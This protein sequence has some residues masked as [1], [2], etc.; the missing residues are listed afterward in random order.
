MNG[1]YSRRATLRRWLIDPLRPLP[2]SAVG[3]ARFSAGLWLALAILGGFFIFFPLATSSET[4]SEAGANYTGLVAVLTAYLLSRYGQHQLAAFTIMMMMCL[5]IAI[6]AAPNGELLYPTFLFYLVIP[7][8]ISSIFLPLI[9]TIITGAGMLI[10]AGAIY[11]LTGATLPDFYDNAPLAFI[12][13]VSLLL[14]ANSYHRRQLER[15]RQAAIAWREAQLRKVIDK[16]PVLV[17]AIDEDGIIRYWNA[18]CER[19]TGYQASEIV[20][21]ANGVN[22]IYPDTSYLQ[23]MLEAVPPYT[24]YRN[25]ITRLTCKDGTTRMVAWSNIAEEIGLE[26]YAEWGVG[27]D[28]T[29]QL[30]RER[31][32]AA[33]AGMSMA[34]RAVNTRAGV[35]RETLDQISTLLGGLGASFALQHYESGQPFLVIE[36]AKNQWKEHTGL[37]IPSTD[38]GYQTVVEQKQ[39]LI[40]NTPAELNQLFRADLMGKVGAFAAVPL[41]V[42]ETVIGALGVGREAHFAAEDIRILTA[43]ADIAANAIRRVEG[44]E[45]LEQ[46]VAERT[47]ALEK[48]YTQLK[49]LDHLKG[50]LLSDIS[51]ELRTPASNLAVYLYLLESDSGSQLSAKRLQTLKDQVMRLNK[52]I[53]GVL[54]ILRLELN[55]AEVELGAV[56]LGPLV[57]L[58]ASPIYARATAKGLSLTVDIP[59][60]LPPVLAHSGYLSQLITH[61]LDNAVAYTL[62]GGIT[63]TAENIPEKRQICL[64]VAD[65][66]IGIPAEDMP[67]LYERFYRGKLA[68]QSNIPG[69]GLGLSLVKGILDVVGGEISISS[70]P[71]IGT[72]V[73]VCLRP[74][75]LAEGQPSISPLTTVL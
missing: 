45:L 6:I 53:E 61:L 31:E 9:G 1:S 7:I 48:A 2:P 25:Y 65:T 63:L 44:V 49:G 36:D 10:E 20:G 73:T 21:R 15:E 30:N 57:S 54:N 29:D 40:I 27:I 52:L 72:T 33:I 17:D 50:K 67:H 12:P 69:I 71:D 28:I 43:M 70:T 60:D 18:E 55:R 34:L 68:G 5:A 46:R 47:A 51:H 37:H 23:A 14:V 4:P 8:I 11:L 13:I 42:G 74:A 41:I 56:P 35:I 32:L 59:A 75:P 38:F 58:T 39:P 62:K 3:H 26:G 64:F 19:V 24:A 16:L 22:V 66:G